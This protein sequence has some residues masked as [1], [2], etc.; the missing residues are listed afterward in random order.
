MDIRCPALL[1]CHSPP[2]SLET[3]SLP[4]SG[5][6]LAV[7]KPSNPPSLPSTVLG[8]QVHAQQSLTLHVST[9]DLNPST[10]VYAAIILTDLHSL[11]QLP[12]SYFLYMFP[13]SG[14]N[15]FGSKNLKRFIKNSNS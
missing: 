15:N 14:R 7:C 1:L 13:R 10:R 9:G 6:R 2:C 8:F 3:E 4:E 12:L 11:Q 5:V